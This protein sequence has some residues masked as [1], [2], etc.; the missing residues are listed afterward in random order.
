MHA[1]Y[2]R[3]CCK[4]GCNGVLEFDGQEKCL[5]HIRHII[6]CELRGFA[7]VHVSLSNGKVGAK[8]TVTYIFKVPWCLSGAL[9]PLLRWLAHLA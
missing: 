9:G 1:V 7:S 6:M 4:D 5:V 3:N 8:S 2:T